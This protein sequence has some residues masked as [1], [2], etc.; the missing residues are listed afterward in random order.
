MQYPIRLR[1]GSP[2][3]GDRATGQY[4]NATFTEAVAALLGTHSG[5]GPGGYHQRTNVHVV[6]T[7]AEAF[8]EEPPKHLRG[9]KG[10]TRSVGEPVFGHEV[11]VYGIDT[12]YGKPKA[13]Q[14]SAGSIGAMDTTTAALHIDLL[15]LAT[16]L[17]VAA[18]TAPVCAVCQADYDDHMAARAAR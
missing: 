11:T 9:G 1:I 10:I 13:A 3:A 6:A 18:N 4:T 8:T 15:T 7:Y 16:N 17:A 14:V 12:A 2:H 5:T